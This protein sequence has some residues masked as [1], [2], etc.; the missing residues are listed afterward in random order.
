MAVL[1]ILTYPDERLKQTSLAVDVFD[2][3]LANLV[4]DLEETM[5]VGPGSVGIA[6]PQ[7]NIFKRIAIVDV[8][9]MVERARAKK[10]R[11]RSSHNGRMVL[12]NPE[13]LE[14]DSEA[15]GRE[16]CLSVPDYTGNVIRAKRIVLQVKDIKGDVKTYHCEGFRILCRATR[17]G[18]PGWLV[19]S[20]QVGQRA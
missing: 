19:V 9:P 20:G 2:P 11:F 16:G 7:V 10:R 8:T 3:E 14:Q 6:A 5:D 17:T 12:I 13:L 18:S 15:T 1:D 4:A